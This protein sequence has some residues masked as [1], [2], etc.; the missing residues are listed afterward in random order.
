LPGPG[1]PDLLPAGRPDG[2]HHI[3][4]FYDDVWQAVGSPDPLP[5]TVRHDVHD[6]GLAL[7]W[8]FTVDPG[9]P[10]TVS[11][12]SILGISPAGPAQAAAAAA[13]ARRH[14]NDVGG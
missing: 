1:T 11:S 8:R 13:V 14:T 7:Q 4:A 3:E 6:S 2:V 12:R 9:H 5:D 10:A